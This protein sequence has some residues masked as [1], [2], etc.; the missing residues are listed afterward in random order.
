MIF[1]LLKML[2]QAA[3]T[4]R[5]DVYR[6]KELTLILGVGCLLRGELGMFVLTRRGY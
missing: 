5:P 6:R 1:W 3:F 2:G 4:R